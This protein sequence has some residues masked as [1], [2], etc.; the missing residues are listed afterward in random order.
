MS[1]RPR[2]RSSLAALVAALVVLALP[3]L[4]SAH[5]EFKSSVP[6]EG[7]TAPSPFSGPVVLT[8]TL[9]LATESKADLIGPDGSRVAA[10]T[11]NG[12][13]MTFDLA[14]PLASGPYQV[15]WTSI[16]DDGDLLRGILKF[17]V[18]PAAATASPSPQPSITPR[19]SA[20]A[21][22]PAAATSGPPT[23]DPSAAAPSDPT[24][25]GID[26]ILPII[27]VLIVVA[28]GAF[29]LVRRNGAA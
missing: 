4:V 2:R 12:T 14:A 20:T 18:A 21:S 7:A 3:Q 17:A 22:A 10:A 8:F 13:T 19:P 1:P 24:G 9:H 28:A 6:A 11:V 16:A 25:G 29:Y 27:V 26:V 5:S 23:P 15:Q